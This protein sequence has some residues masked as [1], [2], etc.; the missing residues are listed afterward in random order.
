MKAV[1]ILEDQLSKHWQHLETKKKWDQWKKWLH[2]IGLSVSLTPKTG[3]IPDEEI[4]F[5]IFLSLCEDDLQNHPEWIKKL[6]TPGWLYEHNIIVMPANFPFENNQSFLRQHIF[7]LSNDL[8]KLQKHVLNLENRIN[9]NTQSILN[10]HTMTEKPSFSIPSAGI[11]EKELIQKHLHLEKELASHQLSKAN[12]PLFPAGQNATENPAD[13]TVTQQSLPSKNQTAHGEQSSSDDQPLKNLNEAYLSFNDWCEQFL[14]NGID[15]Q[16]FS[17]SAIKVD[18]TRP[19]SF[20]QFGY[21]ME[22]K[23]ENKDSFQ[24]VFQKF[25]DMYSNGFRLNQSYE[26]KNPKGPAMEQA[27]PLS[28]KQSYDSISPE[29]FQ[30]PTEDEYKTFNDWLYWLT[31]CGIDPL[32]FVSASPNTRVLKEQSSRRISFIQFCRRIERHLDDVDGFR[33]AVEND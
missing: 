29:S 1:D 19:I 10:T 11:Q 23:V 13:P 26:N 9:T 18:S 25:A 16:Q 22:R 3:I 2:H 30:F 15:L 20:Q 5:Q 6:T 32:Q 7:Q 27:H 17:S 8:K 24:E 21:R 12:P 4:N 33:H 14:K 31:H 28:E